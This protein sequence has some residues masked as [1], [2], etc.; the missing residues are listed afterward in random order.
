VNRLLTDELRESIGREVHY[1]APEAL[2]AASI[3]Y[4]AQAIGSDPARW[5]DEAPPTLVCE[6]N[7]LTG[8]AEGDENAYLGHTWE[9]PLPVPCVMIR[10]GNDYRFGR[11]VRPGDRIAT[12]WVLVDA[13]ERQAADGTPLLFVTARADYRAEDG[14]WLASNTET[15][16]YRAEA[17]Q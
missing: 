17:S 8:V 5:I 12:T 14:E 6:T 16:I 4:F 1:Q 13:A 7:Q 11:P 10:G 3:R 9:L 2:S 15:L